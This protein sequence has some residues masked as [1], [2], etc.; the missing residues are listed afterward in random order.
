MSTQGSVGSADGMNDRLMKYSM[1]MMS[2]HWLTAVLVA[3]AYAVSEGQSHFHGTPPT[4]HA[5]LGLAV[6]ALTVP[7]LIARL[8]G[9]IPAPIDTANKWLA[10]VARV[11]HLAIYFLLIAVPL[12]GWLTLS[13]LGLHVEWLGY[14]L[15]LLT[16]TAPGPSRNLG[17][18]HQAGGNLLI[19]TAVLHAA[20][21]L[22]H[23][24]SIRDRTLQR[25]SPF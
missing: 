17:A 13:R 16:A 1:L 22:W 14:H 9:E 25:M 11:G 23:F 6:L 5:I 20:M 24:F 2:L 3:A 7:R 19:I 4:L 8:I 18:V 10:R 12:T 21:A 15:P